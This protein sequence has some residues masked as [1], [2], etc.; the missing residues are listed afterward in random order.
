MTQSDQMDRFMSEYIHISKYS[1]WRE[2]LG[3]REIW[4][5]TVDRYIEFWESKLPTLPRF[6]EH[7][8]ELQEIYQYLPTLRQ[9]IVDMESMPSMRALMTAG[10]ALQRDEIAGYNCTAI[11]V[12]N[13]AVF[14]EAFYILMNGCFDKNTMIKTESGDKKISELSIDDKVLTYDEKTGT[15]EYVN[16]FMVFETPQSTNE[17][18]VEL[19]F[20][21]GSIFKCTYNH[22][23]LTTNRGWVKAGELTEDDDVKNFHELL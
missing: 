11:A 22:E 13:I 8:N 21:D 1:R 7:P 14:S 4:V 2:S 17:K 10:K 20:E 23:F 19:V 9:G 6:V 15:Y 3:R 18:K 12:N 16:P 5:E